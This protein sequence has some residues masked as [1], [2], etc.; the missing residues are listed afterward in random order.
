MLSGTTSALAAVPAG[1][2]EHEHGMGAGRDGAGDLGEVGVH[3]LGVGEGQDEARRRAARRADG[4][5][6]VGPLVAGVAR[7]PR[8]R[9]AL[10]PDPGERALLADAGLVLEPDLERLAP[11]RRSGRTAGDRLGKLYGMARPSGDGSHSVGGACHERKGAGDGHCD[12]RD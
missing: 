12:D 9:A 6:D 7:R 3:R 11:G 4:A 8:P 1:A 5:E 2:V 10:R